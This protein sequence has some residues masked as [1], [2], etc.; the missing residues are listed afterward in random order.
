MNKLFS[1]PFVNVNTETLPT[2]GF[3]EAPEDFR[4]I[5]LMGFGPSGEGEHLWLEV[6]KREKNTQDLARDLSRHFNVEKHA[7]TY[8]GLKDK[9]AVTR[10]WFSVHL[11]GKSEPSLPVFRNV[12]FLSRTRH[13]KKLKTGVHEGNRFIITLRSVSDMDSLVKNLERVKTDGFPNYFGSQ[14]FGFD[15]GNLD[16]AQEWLTSGKRPRQRFLEGMY[17]S[18]MRSYIFN[19]TLSERIQAGRWNQLTQGE[20]GQFDWSKSGF[21]VEDE[22]DPRCTEGE[23]HPAINLFDNRS[24]LPEPLAELEGERWF[25]QFKKKRFSPEQRALRVIPRN[26]SWQTLDAESVELTF[27]LPKGSYATSCLKEVCELIEPNRDD[28]S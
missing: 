17:L 6:E 14:R 7:V 23:I 15:R 22:Q 16:Q 2:V 24:V 4:V 27:E 5:E 13:N 18:A 25:E 11:P 9:N 1:L 20:I 19:V 8:S 26:F 28:R 12:E 3:K 21:V 10:Q